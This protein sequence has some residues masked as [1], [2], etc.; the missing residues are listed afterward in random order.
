MSYYILPKEYW[1]NGTIIFGR[2]FSY[3]RNG[4]REVLD[5]NFE[6]YPCQVI[7]NLTEYGWGR[8]C[9]IRFE[10]DGRYYFQQAHICH[11]NELFRRD[12]FNVYGDFSKSEYVTKLNNKYKYWYNIREIYNN[13]NT[14]YYS[15]SRYRDFISINPRY[16][17]DFANEEDFL[18]FL[19]NKPERIV[20]LFEFD[21][22]TYDVDEKLAEL[23]G[24]N[25]V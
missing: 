23:F 1:S 25:D 14:D 5:V 18:D 12:W 21:R 13:T 2:W 3:Q 16:K 4:K 19:N 11:N 10:Y 7:S 6:N 17:N 9:F 24:E 8:Y 22:Y 15:G 20:P